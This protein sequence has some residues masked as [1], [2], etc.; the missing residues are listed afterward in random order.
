LLKADRK[1]LSCANLNMA[2]RTLRTETMPTLWETI[3]ISS[4]QAWRFRNDYEGYKAFLRR[5]MN[6]KGAKYVRYVPSFWYLPRLR[7]KIRYLIFGLLIARYIIHPWKESEDHMD[8]RTALAL[9]HYCEKLIKERQHGGHRIPMLKAS[10]W[11][12][13]NEEVTCYLHR[14]FQWEHMD[15]GALAS[16]IKGSYTHLDDFPHRTRLAFHLSQLL[17]SSLPDPV[18]V[19]DWMDSH[20][21]AKEILHSAE[22]NIL[23]HCDGLPDNDPR[24]WQLLPGALT[25]LLSLV[26]ARESA[27]EDVSQ[28][29]RLCVQGIS[30][31]A[32]MIFL[33]MVSHGKGQHAPGMRYDAK[34]CNLRA[35]VER[36]HSNPFRLRLLRRGDDFVPRCDPRRFRRTA[37]HAHRP[38]HAEARHTTAP[39]GYLGQFYPARRN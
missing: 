25:S 39:E 13:P 4:L 15:M 12:Q 2:T 5:M 29:P 16:C 24:W 1:D 18:N 36:C 6:A 33:Q 14:E 21:T 11:L 20:P 28:E 3:S 8:W 19:T 38:I 9:A 37:R 7:A 26:M 30:K 23:L 32:A 22:V 10:V 27:Q 34:T 31:R 17:E 35:A